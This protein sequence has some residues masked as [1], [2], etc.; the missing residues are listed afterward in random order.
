[1]SRHRSKEIRIFA[2][3]GPVPLRW[4]GEQYPP[5]HLA[6]AQGHKAVAEKWLD[7]DAEIDAIYDYN[8]TPMS[9]P[10]PYGVARYC[11]SAARCTERLF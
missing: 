10:R 11:R 2:A 6:V 5:L 4:S 7:A 3:R 8:Y 1:M 9:L